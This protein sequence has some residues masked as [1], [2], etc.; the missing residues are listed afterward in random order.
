MKQTTQAQWANQSLIAEEI[1]AIAPIP[2]NLIDDS[3]FPLWEAI[4]PLLA[5]ACAKKLDDAGIWGINPPV[6]TT[7]ARTWPLSIAETARAAS[8]VTAYT[9]TDAVTGLLDAARIVSSQGYNADGAIVS[10]GWEFR[11]ATARAQSVV[12]NPAGATE[13]Y[14]LICAG[15][16]IKTRPLVW[17]P[18]NADVMVVNW[19]NVIVGMRSDINIKLF[20][21]GVISDDTGKVVLNLLQQDT[22]AARVTMRVGFR[23]V[24]QQTDVD[25]TTVM[26]GAATPAPLTALSPA[27]LVLP[28]AA[29]RSDTGCGTTNA[30]TAVTDT[31]AV[32]TDA[33]LFISGPNI[34]PGSM[35]VSVSVGAGYTISQ[36]ATATGSALTFL[37]GG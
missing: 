20:D 14:P 7:G 10:N 16:G 6:D 13:P 5:R 25:P 32:A 18:R 1:A 35:I 21:T 4:R 33:G 31:H 8:A 2:Q 17:H 26:N 29:A 9:A 19:S 27:A 22:V 3:Q 12:A 37:V 34:P 23:C 28:S 30:S 24:T 36:P 15:M 11:A